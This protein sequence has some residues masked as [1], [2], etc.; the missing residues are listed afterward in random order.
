MAEIEQSSSASQDDDDGDS[1]FTSVAREKP[2]Q[3]LSI[4]G[5]DVA[6]SRMNA[7]AKEMK[8]PTKASWTPLKRLARYLAGTQ[9]VR[10]APMKPGTDYDPHEALLR[11]RRKAIGLGVSIKDR[12]SQS[13][14]KIEVDGCPL[15]S[16]SRMQKARAHSSGEA[17][18]CAAASATSEA[19]LIRESPVVHGTGSSDRNLAGRC[20]HTWHMQT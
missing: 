4:D 10:V 8:Q 20:S 16:A 11:V 14:L 7:C 18:Y 17:E 2:M 15:C 6:N 3:Y 5:C 19:M 9:S 13:S 1:E 12:K